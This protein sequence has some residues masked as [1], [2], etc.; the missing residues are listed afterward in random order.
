MSMGKWLELFMELKSGNK[1][2]IQ[3]ALKKLDDAAPRDAIR[4]QVSRVSSS[5]TC[6][7]EPPPLKTPMQ[8]PPASPLERPNG[9]AYRL[10]NIS[11]GSTTHA[12]HYDACDTWAAQTIVFCDFETRNVGGCDLTKAGAS[13]YAADP[14]TEI[15]CFGY[16]VGDSDYSWSHVSQTLLTQC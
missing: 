6:V 14:A 4:L 3:Q 13:R 10:E 7:D 2:A 11:T 1:D 16:R 5:V 8:E 9:T 15:L 12:T